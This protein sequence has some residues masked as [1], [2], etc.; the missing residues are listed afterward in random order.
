M[1]FNVIPGNEREAHPPGR[2]NGRFGPP[3]PAGPALTRAAAFEALARRRALSIRAFLYRLVG[4]ME[5]AE[6]LAQ[7]TFLR[8]WRGLGDLREGAA[9]ETWLFRI[10]ANLARDHLRRRKRSPGFRSLGDPGVPALSSRAGA[11]PASR[12]MAR[13]GRDRL[14]RAL[15]TL[16]FLQRAALLLKVLQGLRCGEIAGILD[17]TPGS[18]KSSIHLARKRL[19][20]LLEDRTRP[21]RGGEEK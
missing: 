16:P 11:D 14:E 7:E 18:V 8:A 3:A 13:E 12:A 6:D 21:L 15:E 17:T 4:G 2:G 20:G 9:L 1:E 19:A 5:E 10:A